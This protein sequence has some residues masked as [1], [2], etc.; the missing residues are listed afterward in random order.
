MNIVLV[1]L[2]NFQEY[3]L[4]N[5]KQLVRL[6]HNNIYILTNGSL[7]EYFKDVT[8]HVVL[9]DVELL[10]D[11]YNFTSRCIIDWN[12]RGGFWHL[13][14]LRFFYIYAFMIKYGIG[15][16]IHLENDVLVYYNCDCLLEK[17]DK[18]FLYIPFDCFSRNIAS[19]LYIPTV[20]VFR[21]I[22]DLYSPHE[23]D[24][25]NFVRIKRITALIQNFPIFN[26]KLSSNSEIA[27][28]SE[29]FDKFGYIFDAAAIGQ[30]LGGIDP[31]N[32]P[33]AWSN[34]IHPINNDDCDVGHLNSTCVIRYN[35]YFIEWKMIDTIMRPFIYIEGVKIPIFNLHLH[36]KK[37]DK[38]M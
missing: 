4:T 22:L 2:C 34:T 32:N 28:V 5:I 36:C 25:Q 13:A 10:N 14:S 16:I 6:G 9:I 15:D 1:C 7:F 38:Y 12:F 30:Y 33:T 26:D 35:L 29:N 21:Q 17:V 24:M 19:I 18:N 20:D 23:N 37:L 8:E 31:R 27:F 11:S 3:I